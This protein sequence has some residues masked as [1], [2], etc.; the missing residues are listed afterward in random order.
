MNIILGSSSPFRAKVLNEA[1]IPFTVMKPGIDEKAFGKGIESPSHLV[2]KLALAKAEAILARK[3]EPGLLITS[4][5]VV[6]SDEKIL[7][8][9][10]FHYQ[11]RGWLE[12]YHLCPPTTYTSVVVTD[13]KTRRQE[14]KIDTACVIFRQISRKA[15]LSAI[16]R[17]TIMNCCGAFD[18]DDPDLAPYIECINGERDSVIGLPLKVVRELSAKLGYTL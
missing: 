15:I 14:K 2:I 6:V 5:Q 7:E 4:D 17:G 18:L 12:N 11:A 1:G 8:K 13:V 16:A 3:P 9:P 10:D